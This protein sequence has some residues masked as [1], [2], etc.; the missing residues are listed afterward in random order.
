MNFTIEKI[1]N[2]FSKNKIDI[3]RFLASI[4]LI[5]NTMCCGDCKE[6][7]KLV[8]DSKSLDGYIWI[9]SNL[10]K[11]IQTNVRKFSYFNNIRKSFKQCFLFTI[12]V[13]KKSNHKRT[14]I[15]QKHTLILV[16]QFKRIVS[17][18][19]FKFFRFSVRWYR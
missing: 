10:H 8:V 9:C 12:G 4:K 17:D 5:K 7:M 2:I 11:K 15:K 6:N 3:L 16:P 19:S 1:Y 14:I 13:S 18:Y